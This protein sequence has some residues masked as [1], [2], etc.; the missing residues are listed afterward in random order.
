MTEADLQLIFDASGIK[1]LT[2][3]IAK[4]DASM[5][6]LIAEGNKAEKEMHDLGNASANAGQQMGGMSN[7]ISGLG[8]MLASAGLAIGAAEILNLG[9]SA[10]QSAINYET[11]SVQFEVFLGSAEKATK[12][13]A[14][15]NKFS[16]ETPFTPDQVNASGRALLAFGFTTEQLIPTLKM[17]GDVSAAVGKDFNELAVIYGKARTAGTLY[18]E[19]INQLTEAGIPIMDELAKVLGV[20][21]DQ[22]KKLGS[23]GKIS[24]ATLETAFGNMTGEGGRFN[25]MMDKM[26]QSTAGLM[27]TIE[28][29]LQDELRAIGQAMLPTVR[30]IAEG[31]EPA[32]KAV[33]EAFIEVYT[34][35]AE[36]LSG[37][38]ELF[39]ALG[40][41]GKEG[42]KFAN[43]VGT[44]AKALKF[45]TI[46]AQ[47]AWKWISFIVKGFA[48]AVVGIRDFVA[49]SPILMGAVE[50]LIA[51]FKMLGDAIGWVGDKLG[52]GGG[53]TI[54]AMEQYTATMRYAGEEV[55]KLGQA[56]G[57][58]IP[59]I[60]GFTKQI[61]L[62]RYAGLSQA[63][64]TKRMAGDMR[65]YALV[66]R[67]TAAA[68]G[69]VTDS[70]DKLSGAMAKAAGPAAGSIAFLDAQMKAL[71]ESFKQTTSQAD[72][73]MLN[74]KIKAIADEIEKM[75]GKI[76]PANAALGGLAAKFGAV[77]KAAAQTKA[78]M[79]DVLAA[80]AEAG[81]PLFGNEINQADIL[82][83]KLE[84]I[85]KTIKGQ[86]KGA[87]VDFGA[88]AAMAIGNA[89]G[90]GE[91]VGNVFK[92]MIAEMLVQIP[93]L[94]GMALLN[95]AT[96]P[97]NSTIALPLAVA[98]L[99]LLGLSGLIGGIQSKNA[100]EREMAANMNGLAGAGGSAASGGNGR[101]AGPSGLGESM[102][103]VIDITLNI[104]GQRLAQ[105]QYDALKKEQLKRR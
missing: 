102:G 17:V 101:Q 47:L 62:S 100:Q 43:I 15:L 90:M 29:K 81:Q 33:K 46:P 37:F 82:N 96:N 49:N 105:L 52:I 71:Q 35:M 32:F 66:A 84:E 34:P 31:F 79:A 72:R 104:D 12:V 1:E 93:K 45:L 54:T 53:G 87:F 58:T 40:L 68:T 5:A 28:G 14:D 99:A 13:L 70:M 103:G 97:V 24:F 41:G 48:D 89:I 88:S 3:Q 18:A 92:N 8:G 85:G 80:N 65:N 51:P 61:D 69:G 98:G 63:E 77:A 22:V 10:I 59:E 78:D 11:L 20:Q 95:A 4:L 21:A 16:I 39:A 7:A 60:Q 86:L 56:N 38:G 30:I 36:A 67:A 2:A 50:V 27:S 9:K 44:M 74:F 6:A 57:L 55:L 25:G 75:S 23:E 83:A 42:N 76:Q 73:D 19:D 26:S 64:A 91:S 94:A